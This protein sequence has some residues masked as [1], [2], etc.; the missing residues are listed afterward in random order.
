MDKSRAGFS[1]RKSMRGFNKDDVI[2][3]ISEEN[4]RFMQE[5][6]DYEDKLRDADLQIAD[7]LKKLE[8]LKE[9]YDGIL[10]SKDEELSQIKE[11]ASVTSTKLQEAEIRETQAIDENNRLQALLKGCEEQLTQY[12]EKIS[13]YES[14]IAAAESDKQEYE[15]VKAENEYI[16]EKY[17][18]LDAE[19]QAMVMKVRAIESSPVS[20]STPR[21]SHED[22]FQS[23]RG[24]ISKTKN[25]SNDE[26]KQGENGYTEAVRRSY[27]PNTQEISEKAITSILAIN[28]NVKQYMND[29]VG[30]FDS[31]SR[32][33]AE[34]LTRLAD[35]ISERCR[36]LDERIK[37]H[38]TLVSENID[39]I[40]G[41][42][43]SSKQ[44][45]N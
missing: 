42:Y 28:D 24:Y 3:Y 25:G 7:M 32:D 34:G 4:K 45:E 13:Q 18:S 31:Y 1:F 2:Q 10:R 37:A 44:N 39:S 16:R 43:D 33:I 6:S 11:V 30:E 8:E 12:A 19:F 15:R 17:K 26:R 35:E 22:P 29:C 9:Y 14:I 38:K 20:Y 27:S 5:K 21:E 40:Y 41:R 23:P 36:M